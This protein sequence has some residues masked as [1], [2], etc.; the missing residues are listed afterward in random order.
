MTL[1]NY[2]HF[3]NQSDWNDLAE[4][5]ASG[6]FAIKTCRWLLPQPQ[7]TMQPCPD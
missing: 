5:A 2:L 6:L 7:K 4:K 1:S 3:A